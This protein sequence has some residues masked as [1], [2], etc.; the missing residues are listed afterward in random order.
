MSASSASSPAASSRSRRLGSASG[1]VGKDGEGGRGPRSFISTDY[2]R[3]DISTLHARGTTLSCAAD[4]TTFVFSGGK[5]TDTAKLNG[6]NQW[7][8]ADY[9]NTEGKFYNPG[10]EMGL[11]DQ[12]PALER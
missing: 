2:C 8:R 3:D 11:A 7:E 4:A 1:R 5:T 6:T 10:S 9:S 12:H